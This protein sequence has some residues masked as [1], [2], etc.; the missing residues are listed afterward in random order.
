MKWMIVVAAALLSAP[1][2]A[3]QAS[4]APAAA[5]PDP[6]ALDAARA[7]LRSNN[8]EAQLGESARQNASATFNTFLEAAERRQGPMPADLRQRVERLVLESV[9]AM[10]EDMKPTALDEAA[11]VYARYFT[12]AEI[13]ELR[14]LQ[15]NPVLVKFKTF[16][17]SFMSELMQIGARAAAERM[18]DLQEKLKAETT[19]WEKQQ[20][21]A[22]RPEKTS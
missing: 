12:A 21:A 16:A 14:R 15:D 18:P 20:Q 7:L 13:E 22:R 6:A 9:D 5:Q 17:P 19:A 8:F 3:Q 10:V 11:A 4:P 1:V 2:S